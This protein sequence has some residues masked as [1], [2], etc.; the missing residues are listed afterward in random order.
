MGDRLL[1]YLKDDSRLFTYRW[2]SS[3]QEGQW[4]FNMLTSA[5]NANF[6]VQNTPD[7]YQCTL[8][9]LL[10]DPN[11]DTIEKHLSAL[12]TLVM[13][14]FPSLSRE[15]PNLTRQYFLNSMPGSF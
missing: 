2:L 10:W 8:T 12:R 7:F 13:Q 1:L 3:Y 6:H 11:K 14:A 4:D 15:W 5:L 9:T